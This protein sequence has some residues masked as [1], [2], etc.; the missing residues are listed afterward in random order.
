MAVTRLWDTASLLLHLSL[1]NQL[2]RVPSSPLILPTLRYDVN[3]KTDPCTF[4]FVSHFYY[5]CRRV[6][7]IILLPFWAW[8]WKLFRHVTGVQGV[9][10]CL[11]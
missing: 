4:A 2:W 10:Q 6:W 9:G 7:I 1:S 3:N 5:F 8:H 11:H